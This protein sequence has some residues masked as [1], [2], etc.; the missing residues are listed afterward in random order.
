MIEQDIYAATISNPNMRII[1]LFTS[2]NLARVPL[3]VLVVVVV[4]VD[5]LIPLASNAQGNQ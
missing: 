4:A 3:Q 5:L 2:G 1:V